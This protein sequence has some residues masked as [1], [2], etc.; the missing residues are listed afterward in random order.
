MGKE[1]V[2]EVGVCVVMGLRCGAVRSGTEA[3][4]GAVRSGTKAGTETDVSG[5]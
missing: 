4:S 2:L 5:H 1:I 3:G